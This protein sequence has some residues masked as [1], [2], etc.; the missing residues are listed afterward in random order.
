MRKYPS[1]RPQLAGRSECGRI[2]KVLVT[3]SCASMSLLDKTR[4]K[5]TQ[6]VVESAARVLICRIAFCLAESVELTQHTSTAI[7]EAKSS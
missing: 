2:V 7:D 4:R 1:P 5:F 3:A 6:E